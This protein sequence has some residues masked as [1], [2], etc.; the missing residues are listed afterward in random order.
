MGL[1]FI[2]KAAQTYKKSWDNHLVELS[3]PTLFTVEPRATPRTV[4]GDLQTDHLPNI[5]ERL[6]LRLRASQLL[7]YRGDSVVAILHTPPADIL[8]AAQ[9]S[10]GVVCGSVHA[11]NKISRV[12]DIAIW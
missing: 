10:Y 12:V 1:D 2:A 7:A 4:C 5:G 9:A 3:T 8:H 11:V 6:V